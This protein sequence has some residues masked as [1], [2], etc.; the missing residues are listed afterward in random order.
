[1]YHI[2]SANSSFS[3]LFDY[4]T[5]EIIDQQFISFLWAQ[6]RE[7]I[8]YALTLMRMGKS[9][10]FYQEN[11]NCTICKKEIMP[12]FA[13]ILGMRKSSQAELNSYVILLQDDTIIQK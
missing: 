9:N 2:E 3:N 10:D 4:R 6:G 13:A 8:L 11:I 7:K 1:L 12:C 5:E